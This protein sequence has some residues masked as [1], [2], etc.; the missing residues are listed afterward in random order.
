MRCRGITSGAY[1]ANDLALFDSTARFHCTPM[2]VK[3]FG[4]HLGAVLD[5]NIVAISFGIAR[6]DDLAIPGGPYWCAAI[7]R[8]IGAAMRP[9]GF[10]DGV[11]TAGIEIRANA[12]EIQRGAQKGFAHRL[13]G[14][15]VV[16][17]LTVAIDIAHGLKGGVLV[18]KFRRENRPG[19]KP[20]TVQEFLLIQN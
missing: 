5:D 2:K 19:T 18:G 6:R 8:I 12:T 3:I 15:R 20:L 11:K 14:W 17:R 9:N 7:S 1:S 10:S 13:S 16:L 4:L